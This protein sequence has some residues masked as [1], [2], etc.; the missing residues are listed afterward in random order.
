[1]KKQKKQAEPDIPISDS[2][3]VFKAVPI[4]RRTDT[5]ERQFNSEKF[6]TEEK[7]VL[8]FGELRRMAEKLESGTLTS[9]AATYDKMNAFCD[10][11]RELR[12]NSS[13]VN[14][15]S[16]YAQACETRDEK[17]A[18]IAET[19]KRLSYKSYLENFGF[20]DGIETTIKD[21]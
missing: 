16:F 7:A 4:I 18:K 21:E 14:N 11:M 1:M 9:K 20:E 19:E 3:T 15:A 6:K 17:L 8:R 2:F 12:G 5:V 10:K 13:V